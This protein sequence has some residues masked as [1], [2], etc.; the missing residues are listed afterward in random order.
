MKNY[1]DI[2][3]KYAATQPDRVLLQ[4]EDSSYSYGWFKDYADK[5]AA[6]AAHQLTGP[7][8]VLVLGAGPVEQAGAFLALQKIGLL[9][10]IMHHDFSPEDMLAIAEK[11]SLQALWQLGKEQSTWQLTGLPLA[12]HVEND[13][14]GALTSGSTGL[15]K[16]LYRTFFSWAGFFPVQN[17]IFHITQATVMLFHGS[18]S[19]TGNLSIF[20]SVLNEGGTLVSGLRLSGRSWYQL[21]E[22][23]QVNS[24]YLVPAKLQLLAARAKAPLAGLKTII[25][26]SQLLSA[27]NIRDLQQAFP[28]MELI[29]YYGAS[30]L[31]YI[32]YAICDDPERDTANLGKPFPG[33]G[34]S[35]KD[36]AIYVD[37]PY[38]VSGVPIPF[39]CN[40]GGA[41]N[42]KGELIFAGR[43]D[44]VINR[45]GYKV[46]SLKVENAIKALAEVADAVVLPYEDK[47]RGAQIAAFV[48]LKESNPEETAVRHTIR[49]AMDV[50]DCPDKIIFLAELPLNDRGK[51]DKK[52]LSTHI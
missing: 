9:P 24:L 39:T 20:V 6:E 19:F 14:M 37:T 30:E 3:T 31:N 48:V 4:L 34:V 2:L 38:H 12:E 43:K 26:G 33:F 22:K 49:H 51:P 7:A 23:H 50:R 32:T 47:L 16:V 41:I 17:E 44:Y 25:T 46:N 1:Y 27:Q 45:G 52:A 18:L 29:L 42:E 36:G 8:A 28:C 40:D 13:I 5:L 35:I 11:N 10:I 21:L 15:P